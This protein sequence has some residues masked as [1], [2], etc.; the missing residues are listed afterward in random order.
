M[1]GGYGYVLTLG[2]RLAYADSL[3]PLAT[4]EAQKNTADP[5]AAVET[6]KWMIENYSRITASLPL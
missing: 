3:K 6:I 4:L 1:A 5:A 2:E